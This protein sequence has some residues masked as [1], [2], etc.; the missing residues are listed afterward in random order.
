MYYQPAKLL[1]LFVVF[2]CFALVAKA[3][4]V[5]VGDP[6][7]KAICVDASTSF[8][9]I[10]VNTAAY[11]WQ[12]ND[13]VGWYNITAAIGYATGF[14]SPLLTIS[15]ANLGLNGYLYRCVVF[16]AAGLQDISNSASLG[17]YDPPIITVSPT[18]TRVCKNETAVF[19]VQSLNATHYKWQENIGEG[20]VNIMDN[21]FYQGTDSEVLEVFTT[22][23]MN[24][25]RFRCIVTNVSCP[26]T[27][28]GSQLFVDPTPV[29]QQIT[30]GG[31]YCSGGIGVE[32]GLADSETGIS[33]QLLRNGNPTGNVIEGNNEPLSF[34]FFTQEGEY[35]VLAINGFTSCSI[36]MYGD[37]EVEISPLPA[38]Q[39]LLGGGAYCP[40]ETAPEI[41]LAGTEAGVKY[42]LFLN[43]AFTGSEILGNGFVSSFGRFADPGLYSVLAINSITACSVQLTN[44]LQVIQHPKPVVFAGSNQFIN[45][46]EIANLSASASGGSGNYSYSWSPQAYVQQPDIASTQTIPLFQSRQFLI[47]ATDLQS[48]CETSADTLAVYVEDG[49]LELELV[50]SQT[51]VCPAEP[52]QLVA[53]AGGG[54]GN[55]TYQWTSLPAGF[56]SNASQ[57]V[58]YPE[59]STT[60]KVVLSDGQ[61]SLQKSVSIQVNPVPAVY[62]LTGEGDFCAG[63]DG[64][65]LG[66]NGSE[67]GVIY[68]L[69]KNGESIT[70]KIG[71]GQAI[72]FG[73]FLLAGTYTAS[74]SF[75]QNSCQ[76]D[77]QGA[78]QLNP[79]SLPIVVAGPNQYIETGAQTTLTSAANGGSGSYQYSWTPLDK[80]LNP[81]QANAATL[82]LFETTLFEV[83]A[84]DAQTGCISEGAQSVVFITGGD[85]SLRLQAS[86]YSICPGETVQLQGLPSGGSGSYEFQWQ[87]V[88]AGFSS[89][90]SNPI[91]HPI[92]STKFLLTVT[93]G[94][95]VITDSLQ[96]EVRPQPQVF[97]LTGGGSYCLGSNAQDI[98]LEGSENNVFYSLFRNGE[99]TGLLR[100]G[101]EQPIV[102]GQ[103]N[104]EGVYR[105]EAFSQQ[106][107]CRSMMPGNVEVNPLDVPEIFAGYDRTIQS[108]TVT[109]LNAQATGGSG[110][111]SFSWSPA[112]QVT[113]PQAQQ[114]LTAPLL[115]NTVFTLEVVDSQ[116]NCQGQADQVQVFVQ[117][118][119]LIVD[120]SAN[121]TEIC[122]GESVSLNANVTGGTASYYYSWTSSPA[123]FYASEMQPIATPT[124]STW[125]YL[126]VYDGQETAIDSVFVQVAEAPLTFFVS[127]GGVVCGA[128]Q[129]KPLNLS[130][131]QSGIKYQLFHDNNLLVEIFGNGQ[132][133]QFGNFNQPGI[134][135]VMAISANDICVSAMSGEAIIQQGIVPLANA[136][137]DKWIELSGQVTL[138]GSISGNE[139]AQFNWNPAAKLLNPEVLQPTTIVLDKTTLYKLEANIPGCGSS[140]DYATVFVTGGELSLDIFA[141]PATCPG[142]ELSLFALPSG[143]TGNYSYQWTSYPAGFESNLINPLI[144]PQQPS[145]YILELTDGLQSI[146]DSVLIEPLPQPI[147]F[148]VS[149]G[150]SFCVDEENPELVLSGSESEAVYTLYYNGLQTD[151]N[152]IGSGF[153]LNFEMNLGAGNYQVFAE[154]PGSSCS[155]QMNGTASIFWNAIPEVFA[156]F[157]QEVV[158]GETASLSGVAIGGS[159]N[160]AYSW[161][162][163]W[164]LESPNQAATQT[165]ALDQTTVF[166]FSATDTESLCVSQQDTTVVFVS[167]GPLTVR[168]VSDQNNLC[169]GQLFTALA[170][171]SGGTGNYTYLWTN[172]AGALPGEAEKLSVLVFESSW[173]Y[174]EVTDGEDIALNST[175]VTVADELQQFSITGGGSYCP[176]NEPP[177]IG[178]SGSE[179]GIHYSLLRNSQI[180]LT[181]VGQGDA[182]SFGQFG[183]SGTYTVEAFRPGFACKKMMTASAVVV[184]HS[185][186]EISAGKDQYI[187]QGTSTTVQASVSG[188]SGNYSYQWQPDILLNTPEMPVSNTI[189]LQ[190]SAVFEVELTDNETFCTASDVVNVFVTGGLLTAQVLAD[191][192]FVCPGQPVIIS[193]LPSGGTGEYTWSWTANGQP[194]GNG[195]MS[196]TAYPVVDTWFVAIIFSDEQMLKDSVLVRIHSLPTI[197][198]LDGGGAY[199]ENQAPPEVFLNDS[200]PG[201]TYKLL[202]NGLYTGL[203]KA[204]TG[205]AVSF[206]LQYAQGNYHSF[207]V[208]EQQCKQLMNGLAEVK[209]VNQPR[210]FQLFGGGRWC[211]NEQG[212]GLY[213]SGSQPDVNYSLLL[214]GELALE[215]ISGTGQAIAFEAAVQTGVYSVEAKLTIANCS[216][217]MR[218]FVSTFI[219]PSPQLMLS[220]NQ[221]A[222]ANDFFN[223]SASGAAQYQ[224]MIDPVATSPDIEI[225]ADEN[226]SFLLIGS[227]SLG[228][229]DSLQINLAVN[230]RPEIEL[231]VDADL[232]LVRIEPNEFQQYEFWSGNEVLQSGSSNQLNFEGLTLVNDSIS[233]TAT[234]SENCVSQAAIY[235]EPIN[236]YNAFSPNG[237]GINDIFREGDFIRVFSRWGV[238]IFSGDQGWD[239]RYNGTMVAP[240]TYYYIHEI[241]NSVGEL[242]RTEK[243][244]VTLVII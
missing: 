223:L 39:Q 171:P 102:F 180:V 51:Q 148:E 190:Q 122:A 42:Q 175:Y 2:F 85:L 231:I 184:A 129:L 214:N 88:P 199:C 64:A 154:I 179:K 150:G 217:Q 209:Q 5:V 72:S 90:L 191:N 55:Y 196:F 156:G 219:D 192:A 19:A 143:G 123:G 141:S 45:R 50:A 232:K 185:S 61:E 3:Q 125:Y 53:L 65:T 126:T 121:S 27:T 233:A 20:W 157:D 198:A 98:V 205:S 151:V 119:D 161:F 7:D 70:E 8:R 130:G 197:Y 54:T 17:V 193:A 11:Q 14:N 238:E 75:S 225:Q 176:G 227:N 201:T 48:G 172:E 239:G 113:N 169:A 139:N 15:D 106:Y 170:L 34:G 117:G 77:M 166:Y 135:T 211:D 58:V 234:T 187:L 101:N 103:Q 194:V 133:L 173:I 25:F 18:D 87:S 95:T 178:L 165:T 188:G 244:A 92:T 145:W 210:I 23:G 140:Q 147:A 79:L 174:L 62:N 242:L 160:Y 82:A 105:V 59:V 84:T 189:V 33:Y 111:Y 229:S 78:I 31:S 186:P 4:P 28:A 97:N 236:E 149:G 1:V 127:G 63:S 212:N 60:Y 83:V 93:D 115:Q 40:G 230:P 153:E 132:T 91:V 220:G 109:N 110:N 168:V 218:G 47:F 207:A 163:D 36:L 86:S 12:E 235:I 24:E 29:I 144:Y 136:G 100:I 221:T 152:Q 224:W 138:E 181:H 107:L 155:R 6:S 76:I 67:N 131:S 35:T 21:A 142:S 69:Y 13:G 237:D 216:Q 243:G 226:L 38:Q 108:G 203:S 49:P 167:G 204:G 116:T 124:V 241:K 128:G 195:L 81:N 215:T 114:T 56:T 46:G 222:C 9:V 137:P 96:I 182:I 202:V 57:A 52:V 99:N 159:G 71:T 74:A 208:N 240:G 80:L 30:G 134:Y 16:D 164:Q 22:T 10:A 37:V 146:R 32:I 120:A 177:S 41:Y 206:G 112:A 228:C 43:G 183:T 158:V 68:K 162:P 104:L 200:D 89:N 118:G 66:L 94:F 44:Q 26:D 73:K 213:L